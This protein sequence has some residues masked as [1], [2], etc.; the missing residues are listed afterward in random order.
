MVI[1]AALN[2][3]ALTALDGLGPDD[4]RYWARLDEL[5]RYTSRHE[6]ALGP[7]LA[8]A[9]TD[10]SRMLLADVVGRIAEERPQSVPAEAASHLASWL[11]TSK[12][13]DALGAELA[14]VRRL[15]AAETKKDV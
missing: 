7:L 2:E 10:S 5:L 14:A 6:Q 13:A 8:E 9:Q 3:E 11:R 12:S 1:P 15:R 4:D